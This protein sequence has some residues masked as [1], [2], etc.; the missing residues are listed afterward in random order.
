MWG[1]WAICGSGFSRLGG[2][3]LTHD[4]QISG[5]TGLNSFIVVIQPS[6]LYLLC[7]LSF[8]FMFLVF[9]ARTCS[10]ARVYGWRSLCPNWWG[11]WRE[12]KGVIASGFGVWGLGLQDA[13]GLRCFRCR[14]WNFARWKK[15]LTGRK[16]KAP[17]R[18]LVVKVRGCLEWWPE[19]NCK[20]YSWSNPSLEPNSKIQSPTNPKPHKLETFTTTWTKVKNNQT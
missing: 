14:V 18:S 9:Y 3:E 17:P 16:N 19:R 4:I 20:V 1:A 5:F 10:Q 12:W 15:A 6:Y 7:S 11:A 2:G 13:G 8:L